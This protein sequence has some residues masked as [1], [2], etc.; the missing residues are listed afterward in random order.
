MKRG[1]RR[2]GDIR[3]ALRGESVG[4][5]DD[6]GLYVISSVSEKRFSVVIA[7]HEVPRQSPKPRAS[8]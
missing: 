6:R 8:Y 4:V 2:G 3:G 1:K 7:R 5:A